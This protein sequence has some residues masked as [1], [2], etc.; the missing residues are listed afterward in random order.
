MGKVQLIH[1][2]VSQIVG[3]SEF[4]LLVLS[5]MSETRQIAI[6][7]DEH[8]EY[9][10]GLR[11]DKKVNTER[12]LPEVLCSINPSM[13]SEHY[14]ILFN[15]VVNGQYKALL[16]NKDDLSLTPMRASDAILLAHIAK[17]N[18]FMEENLFKHQSVVCGSTKNKLAV[19]INT[20][21]LD[22]LQ[23]AL[24]KAIEDENYE[25]ASLLRDE[26]K[27]RKTETE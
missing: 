21:T 19:P 8:M 17:L 9:E 7:C 10:F 25:L 2:G 4:G 11:T 3:G 16:V 1:V 24:D 13:T 22:M 14:E 6:V 18:I 26:L 23:K 5:D 27:H 20:L 15:S 12:L